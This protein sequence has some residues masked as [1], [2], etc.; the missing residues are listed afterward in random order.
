MFIHLL[1]GGELP[2]AL[3]AY[4]DGSR[5]C[6]EVQQRAT[7]STFQV[8]VENLFV[9]KSL[10]ATLALKIFVVVVHVAVHLLLRAVGLEADLTAELIPVMLGKQLLLPCVRVA[11]LNPVIN[12]HRIR[13]QFDKK[14]RTCLRV[15][16][17]YRL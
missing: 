12:K 16:I 8:F 9:L 2:A 1:P 11:Y 15:G 17:R 10:A 6:L 3:V 5:L 13:I 4:T 14:E 7:L